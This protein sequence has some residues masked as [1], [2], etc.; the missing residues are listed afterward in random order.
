MVTRV[1]KMS[2]L[3]TV[4]S[5]LIPLF[6]EKIVARKSI[7]PLLLATA[8]QWLAQEFQWNIH[9]C[10]WTWLNCHSLLSDHVFFKAGFCLKPWEAVFPLSWFNLKGK[11]SSEWKLLFQAT[12]LIFVE[13]TEQLSVWNKYSTRSSCLST[14]SLFI[15]RFAFKN[16]AFQYLAP[17]FYKTFFV[18]L[19][20][21][22]C[23]SHWHTGRFILVLLIFNAFCNCKV[24]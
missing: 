17:A 18:C 12:L 3:K 10:S 24:E 22:T 21:K 9:P 20:N 19:Q 23:I 8:N 1:V 6:Y 4:W 11:Q 13:I 16:S 5:M 2:R 7:A 15:L 14:N